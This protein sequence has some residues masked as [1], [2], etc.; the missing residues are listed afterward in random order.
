MLALAA[1]SGGCASLTLRKHPAPAQVASGRPAGAAGQAALARQ[2]LPEGRVGT[3][4]MI[5]RGGKFVL[6]E[7][8]DGGM[9]ML[10]NGSDLHCRLSAAPG[11][12]S[13]A[14][15]RLS[16]ERRLQFASADVVSGQPR[17][18]DAVFVGGQGLAP[19]GPGLGGI[20]APS[21][22]PPEIG[23]TLPPPSAGGR[24]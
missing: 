21:L 10:P 9:L 4:R 7:T 13:T 16:R 23:G 15:L 20:I 6:V 14:E 22:L 8:L 1:A 2:P 11:A 5:G 24:P 19:T 17:V 12:A 3:V 18:G